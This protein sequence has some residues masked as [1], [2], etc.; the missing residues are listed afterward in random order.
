MNKKIVGRKSKHD[1]IRIHSERIPK[2]LTELGGILSG[3][4]TKPTK[5]VM[6]EIK[7]GWE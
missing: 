5:E 1:G 7:G 6:K 2:N 3:M 4:E